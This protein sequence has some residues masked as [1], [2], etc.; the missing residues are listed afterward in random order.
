M[1]QPLYPTL[2]LTWAGLCLIW[3]ISELSF[4]EKKK[5]KT[6]NSLHFLT[7]AEAVLPLTTAL[8]ALP[9]HGLLMVGILSTDIPP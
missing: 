6:C 8:D 4:Q 1:A 3:A 7:A 9:Q 5:H 2:P